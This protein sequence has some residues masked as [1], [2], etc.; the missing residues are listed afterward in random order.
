MKTTKLVQ[1]AEEAI[2]NIESFRKELHRSPD[3]QARAAY[4]RAWYAYERD[5]GTVI[6][7]P[8]KFIGYSG[9]TAKEYVGENHDRDGRKT[10]VCLQDWFEEVSD[11]NLREKLEEQL[12]DFLAQYGKSPS[13][14]SRINVLRAASTQKAGVG[15]R[16]QVLVE[17]I[18]EVARTLTPSQLRV[19]RGRIAGL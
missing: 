11:D 6:F 2:S 8:S 5:D 10:E 19:L 9:M 12:A 14:A 16:R 1:S 4:S 17:L 18:V 7:G 3:L 15:E 13:R